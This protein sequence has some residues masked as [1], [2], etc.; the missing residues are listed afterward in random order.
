MATVPVSLKLRRILA[1]IVYVFLLVG[2]YYP[3][4][5]RFLLM[6]H[7]A[8]ARHYEGL[9]DETA[10]DYPRFLDEVRNRTPAGSSIAIVFPARQWDRLYRYA[11]IRAS[12]KLAGRRVVP[13][14]KPAGGKA[15]G[16]IREADYLALFSTRLDHEPPPLWSGYRGQ[17]IRARR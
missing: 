7:A 2:A 17:L 3:G 5:L 1:A 13:L 15:P 14:I 12:Y 10:P 9:P 8:M 6:N 11:Y 4:Y 16:R